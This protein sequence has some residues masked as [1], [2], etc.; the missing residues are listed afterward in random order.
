[1]EWENGKGSQL[2]GSGC[3]HKPTF[4]G[5]CAIPPHTLILIDAYLIANEGNYGKA[6]CAC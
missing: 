4:R 3:M 5:L 6:S 2:G 1:M